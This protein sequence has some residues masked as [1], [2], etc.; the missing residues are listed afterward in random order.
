[1][2]EPAETNVLRH[3]VMFKFKDEA[4][5]QQVREVVDAFRALPDQI[6]QILGFE[7]GT[8][9]SEEGHDHGYTHCFTV[10]FGSAADR[11]AYLPHPAH[12]AFVEKLM[13]ILDKVHVF[14]YFARS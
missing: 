12:Q 8:N 2:S 6:D 1:M 10:T 3:V 4:T 13:P 9:N 11:D 7:W 14:D 5:E